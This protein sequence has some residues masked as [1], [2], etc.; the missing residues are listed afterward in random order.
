[1]DDSWL[2]QKPPQRR[3]VANVLQLLK[4]LA[5]QESLDERSII[6]A[7][8]R[9]SRDRVSGP[10]GAAAKL[11]VPSTTLESRIKALNIQKSRF[12]FAGDR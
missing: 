1:M 4:R 10:I 11:K 12:K 8:L 7:A 6:E 5:Q 2:S 9:E 3:R